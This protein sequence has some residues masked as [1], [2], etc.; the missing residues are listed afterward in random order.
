MHRHPLL[1]LE[2]SLKNCS[3]AFLAVR[4]G[5]ATW[6]GPAYPSLLLPC[7]HLGLCIHRHMKVDITQTYHNTGSLP[8][9]MH[10]CSCVMDHRAAMLLGHS[11]PTGCCTPSCCLHRYWL[12]LQPSPSPGALPQCQ[13]LLC[14]KLPQAASMFA[15]SLPVCPDDHS[16]LCCHFFNT[17][18]SSCSA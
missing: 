10:S 3:P 4:C 11:H 14:L 16:K 13:C 8:D 12:Q 17:P 9:H 6:R 2:R 15:T 5:T 18:R 7:P 1:T